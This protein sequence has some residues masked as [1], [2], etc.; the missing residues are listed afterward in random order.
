MLYLSIQEQVATTNNNDNRKFSISSIIYDSGFYEQFYV[1]PS[2]PKTIV[3]IA[4]TI[5]K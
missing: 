1:C 2:V 5:A 4:S 3:G